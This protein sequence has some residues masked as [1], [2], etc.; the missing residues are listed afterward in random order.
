MS[1]TSKTEALQALLEQ[2]LHT[3]MLQRCRHAYLHDVRNGLQAVRAGIEAVNRSL[4]NAST[5]ANPNAGPPEKYVEFMQQAIVGHEKS[6]Q[7]TFEY[8]APEEPGSLAPIDVSLMVRELARFLSNDAAHRSVKV[9]VHVPDVV[10]VTARAHKL[11]LALLSLLVDAIDAMPHGGEL[12][13]EVTLSE[14]RVLVEFRDTRTDHTEELDATLDVLALTGEPAQHALLFVVR[15]LI[16]A[17]QGSLECS[18][19]NPGR[20]VRISLVSQVAAS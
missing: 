3:R 4:R 8:L 19:L 1:A 5:G 6:L 11:R 7:A 16:V 9:G 20:M 17:D 10:L 18:A 14:A 13:V 2:A 12:Q 15:R